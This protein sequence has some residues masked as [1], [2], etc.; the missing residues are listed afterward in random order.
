[1]SYAYI[2]DYCRNDFTDDQIDE[3]RSWAL[4]S[5]RLGLTDQ[6]SLENENITSDLGLDGYYIF[7]KNVDISN[8]AIVDIQSCGRVLIESNF[9]VE[10][11]SSLNIN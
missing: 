2:Y 3:V 11:G 7:I 1:M 4:Q 5:P 10:L 9:S 8:N 6:S